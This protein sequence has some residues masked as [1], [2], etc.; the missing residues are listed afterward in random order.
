MIALSLRLETFE[1]AR[2]EDRHHTLLMAAILIVLGTGALYF[3]FVVQ[4]YYLVDRTLERMKSYTENV[5]ESM[6]DGLI[7]LDREGRIVTLNRQAAEILGSGRERLEGRNIAELLGEGIGE[8]LG[9]AEG[10]ALVRDREMEIREGPGRQDS[11]E[12][13]RGAAQGRC[14]AG[15]GVGAPDQGPAGDPGAPGK[16]APQRAPGVAREAGRRRGA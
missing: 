12:P 5:V 11:P 7:S 16:G 2:R 15:D 14:G 8:I 13:Q 9:P 4:N 1:T 10:R 6:A 3:I